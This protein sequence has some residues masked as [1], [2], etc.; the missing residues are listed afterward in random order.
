MHK[1]TNV[2]PPDEL[3]DRLVY[4]DGDLWWNPDYKH[5]RINHDKPIGFINKQGYKQVVLSV[6]G[7]ARN[8]G[9]SRLIWWWLYDEWPD[10][11]DHI[12]R[13]PLNNEISNLANK[14]GLENCHNRGKYGTN[15]S[16]YIGL[17]LAPS[18]N[19]GY[20]L[21]VN[22]KTFGVTGYKH[23][24][25]AALARD[26]M[27]RLFHGDLTELNLLDKNINIQKKEKY[28]ENIELQTL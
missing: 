14:S 3:R 25:T 8:Y 26:V 4:R 27:A 5:H 24:E 11:I 18:G 19:W 16:G 23:K 7:V 17:H 22:G 9:V 13:N 20:R 2:P 1:F 12:D 21:M 6:D 15:T 10:Q 28:S